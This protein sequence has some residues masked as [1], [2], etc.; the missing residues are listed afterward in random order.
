METQNIPSDDE[1]REY[2]KQYQINPNRAMFTLILSIMVDVFGF[3]MVIPLLPLLAKSLGATDLMYGIIISSNA[4]AIL[5][6][7]PIWGKLSDKYGRK[8]ILMISQAGTGLAFLL[9]AF[10]NSLYII[11]AGRILDGIFSGQFPI[12]RAY[13]SDV[14]TPQTRASQMSKIMVGYTSGMIIGPLLG[15]ILGTFGWWYPMIF[16][17]LLSIISII[18]TLKV[19]V[20]S[21]PRERIRDLK[22]KRELIKA[23]SDGQQKV[24]SRE[25]GIRF[26]QVFLHS[27]ISILFG[28]SLALVL[29]KR[30]NATP[31]I[32]GTIMSITGVVL[33][34]YGLFLM[35]RVI[36][37]IGEK[38][39][40][41]SCIVGYVV[42]FMLYPYLNELWMFYVFMVLYA[43]CMASVYPLISSNITKAVGPD[44][45]G[46]ISGW[47]TNIQSISQTVSPIIS[48]S[49][50]QIGGLT[51]GFIFLNSYQLIGFTIVIISAILL[52]IA[53]IDVK[54]H[55][56]LYAYEKIRRKRKE[57]KKRKKKELQNSKNSQID[58]IG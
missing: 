38:R 49:F 50:L 26:L 41:F 54:K 37:K 55:P 34:V 53:F 11:F 27:L 18:L 32:I 30:F 14:T 17:S 29:F 7:G 15:G 16:A 24:W 39:I 8:P 20:E 42:L 58:I 35:R 31:S 52:I 33:L 23:S 46:A 43:L 47:T 2:L 25:V 5:I 12:I 40:F 44:K 1:H 22:I 13:I 19:L 57:I 48:T 3:S 45:Q 10:S 56:R 51:L 6:F 9:L 28:S 21:M 36:R 4:I